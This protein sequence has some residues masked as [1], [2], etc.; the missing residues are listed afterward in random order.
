MGRDYIFHCPKGKINIHKNGFD[1]CYNCGIRRATSTNNK[2]R[3]LLLRSRSLNTL[4]RN[5][6]IPIGDQS[7]NSNEDSKNRILYNSLCLMAENRLK[8]EKESLETKIDQISNQ[9]AWKEMIKFE[10]SREDR[11][12]Q[13]GEI[14]LRQ[15]STEYVTFPNKLGI[16][17]FLLLFA[18]VLSV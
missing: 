3:N 4:P 17:S 8:V 2:K 6:S 1:L 16:L 5:K 11:V 15:D 18:F 14:S 13:K 9:A 10:Q 12:K 7:K